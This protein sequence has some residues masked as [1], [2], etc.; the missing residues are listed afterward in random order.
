MNILWIEDA[1]NE[2]LKSLRE[3]HFYKSK[4]FDK[5]IHEIFTVESLDESIEKI[6]YHA[7]EYDYFVI[8]LNLKHFRM[9]KKSNELMKKTMGENKDDFLNRAGHILYLLLLGKGVT[10]SKVVFLTGNCTG[11]KL[12]KHLRDWKLAVKNGDDREKITNFEAFIKNDPIIDENRAHEY[13]E[14]GKFDDFL[15]LVESAIESSETESQSEFSMLRDLSRKAM[16]PDYPEAFRKNDD[17][18]NP[19]F[20]NWI[21]DTLTNNNLDFK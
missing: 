18:S 8:D 6:K 16:L 10:T 5:N 15:T 2:T 9:G 1:T 12:K 14:N 7:L 4:H 11:I 19:S 20:H 13:L 3:D 21:E 17:G